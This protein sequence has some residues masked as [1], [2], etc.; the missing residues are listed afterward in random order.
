METVII[1]C[2]VKKAKHFQAKLKVKGD[3]EACVEDT[4]KMQSTCHVCNAKLEVI[5]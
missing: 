4:L 5:R 2:P 3:V 1:Q